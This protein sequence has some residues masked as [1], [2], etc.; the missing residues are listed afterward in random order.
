MTLCLED[1][2]MKSKA[3]LLREESYSLESI[4][5]MGQSKPGPL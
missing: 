1:N 2:E 3:L 5:P 4:S